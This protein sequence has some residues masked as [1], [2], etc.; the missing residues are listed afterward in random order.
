[1]APSPPG[2]LKLCRANVGLVT[3]YLKAH[4]PWRRD[5]PPPQDTLVAE[6]GLVPKSHALGRCLPLLG[7]ILGYGGTL[8]VSVSNRFR[9]AELSMAWPCSQ[10]AST[11][12]VTFGGKSL[13]LQGAHV[14]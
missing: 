4:I 10:H 2:E 13:H 1:M 5:P 12:G 7:W 9:K 14:G 8:K 3:P 11:T 6:P